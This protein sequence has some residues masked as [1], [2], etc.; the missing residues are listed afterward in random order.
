MA[1]FN[2]LSTNAFTFNLLRIPETTFR[3][4]SVEVPSITV[5]APDSNSGSS[6]QW[7]P[8]S[9]TEF[10]EMSVKF[11]VDENLKNYEEIYH[12]ITQQ[13]YANKDSWKSISDSDKLLVSDGFLTTLT[14]NSNPNRVFYFKDMFPTAVG[15]LSFDTENPTQVTCYVNFRFSYFELR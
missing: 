14:N 4:T 15:S 10:D 6:N 13:R 1:D 5:P 9:A 8:G 3:C 12:W 7:F 2:S 11:I